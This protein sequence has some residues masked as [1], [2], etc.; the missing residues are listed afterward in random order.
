M[1]A[2]QIQALDY[3]QGLAFNVHQRLIKIFISPKGFRE[4]S[5]PSTIRESQ[6]ETNIEKPESAATHSAHKQDWSAVEPLAWVILVRVKTLNRY[7]IMAISLK[8]SSLINPSIF[9]PI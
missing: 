5:C 3:K 4:A 8:S 2:E 6:E 9:K 1:K 7:E